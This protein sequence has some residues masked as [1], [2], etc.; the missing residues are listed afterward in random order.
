VTAE[1]LAR[2]LSGNLDCGNG[3]QRR[4]GDFFIFHRDDANEP[5]SDKAAWLFELVRASG[6]CPEPA[7]LNFA[8]CRKVYRADIFKEAGQ[9]RAFRNIQGFGSNRADR[10]RRE[11]LHPVRGATP[12]C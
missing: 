9:C 10:P 12:V 1:I 8:L 5:T 3:L 11:T 7:D 6:L 4:V 2:G